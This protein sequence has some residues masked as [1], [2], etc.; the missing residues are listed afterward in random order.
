MIELKHLEVSEIDKQRSGIAELFNVCFGEALD[1]ALWEWAYLKNP[2]GTP[3]IAVALD[4]G[5]VIGHYAMIP[6]P[7]VQDALPH[8]GYLSMTTMVH[9]NFRRFGLFKELASIAYSN[10]L[11]GTFVYGFP[12]S[13]SAPGFKKRLEWEISDE[14]HIATISAK[15]LASYLRETPV[16]LGG[17]LDIFDTQFIDWRLSKPG[18][19]YCIGGNLIYKEFNGEIDLLTI[20]NSSPSFFMGSDQVFNLL[21]SDESLLSAST[22]HKKY[23]F[24]FRNFNSSMNLSRISPS[25]LMSDVF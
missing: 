5:K 3:I 1:Q 14:F 13:N 16:N 11:P 18:T 6:V 23:H 12:N 24:G 7:F 8:L 10:A 15:T 4:N 21:T 25:L 2:T 19:K 9:P 20:D 17:S 22:V